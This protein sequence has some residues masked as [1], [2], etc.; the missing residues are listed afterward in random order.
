MN[1]EEFEKR[2]KALEKAISANNF[3]HLNTGDPTGSY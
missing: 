3:Q 1:I 2:L